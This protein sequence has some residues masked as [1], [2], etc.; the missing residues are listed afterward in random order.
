MQQSKTDL[1]PALYGACGEF[2]LSDRAWRLLLALASAYGWMPAGT[3]PPDPEYVDDELSHM[4]APWD[5][6]YTPPE[7]QRMTG[8]DARAIADALEHALP[9]IPDQDALS[10]K[11]LAPSAAAPLA[12]WGRPAMPGVTIM[13][14]EEFSGQNKQ[15]LVPLIAHLREGGEIWIC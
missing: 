10:E 1:G 2:S 6:R 9:D 14:M 13:A 11:V 7:C 4:A 3:Q 8:S 15:H 12:L 5:G